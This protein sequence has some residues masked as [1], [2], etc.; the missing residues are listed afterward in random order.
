M[1]PAKYPLHLTPGTIFGPY[2]LYAQDTN[3]DP[4][5]LTGCLP[6]AEVRPRAGSNKLILNLNPSVTDGPGGEITIPKITDEDTYNLQFV[7]ARW[8]LIIEFPGGDRVGP[9]IEDKFI[10]A[11]TPTKPPEA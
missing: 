2:K 3:G 9:Y 5:D 10:I 1:I 6:F 11:G 7:A 8:S 4:V